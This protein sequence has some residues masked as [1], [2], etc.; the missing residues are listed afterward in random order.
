[1]NGPGYDFWTDPDWSS[2]VGSAGSYKLMEDVSLPDSAKPAEASGG[3]V[4]AGALLESEADA[5]ARQYP[6][7]MNPGMMNPG[8]MNPGMVGGGYPM[9]GMAGGMD[10]NM[11]GIPDH[12]DMNMNGIP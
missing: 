5:S 6:G 10:M 11:N 8:M 12:M 3:S 2:C 9:G 4:G 1:M 7:M